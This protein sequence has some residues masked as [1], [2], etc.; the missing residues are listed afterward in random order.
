[1]PSNDVN[2]HENAVDQAMYACR[3]GDCFLGDHG[4]VELCL[5]RTGETALE[6]YLDTQVSGLILVS[7]S[8]DIAKSCA[9]RPMIEVCPL[10]EI[11]DPDIH[12]QIVANKRPKYAAVPAL[13]A[14][15]LVADL[16][17]T[18]TVEKAVVA[19]WQR[20]QGMLTDDDSRA[21]ARALARKRARFAF[22]DDF[23]SYVAPLR[24]RCIEKHGKETD[25]GRA[26]RD[27]QEIRVRAKPSWE[28]EEI[29]LTFYF[30]RKTNSTLNLQGPWDVWKS[31]WLKGLL[32]HTRYTKHEGQVTD[33][34][35]MTAAEYLGSDQLDFEQLSKRG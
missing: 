15:R 35:R 8:C 7:Q 9:E 5:D 3:Q 18:M 27:L 24:R 1:M 28:A 12:A 29:E 11:G 19:R 33:Y 23:S 4:F 14:Q 10:V 22:P 34:A 13:N 17:R 32:S 16:D 25:E 20:T 6:E 26:L 21:F 30:V 31:G 2:S